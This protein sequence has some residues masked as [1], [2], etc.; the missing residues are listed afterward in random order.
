MLLSGIGMPGVTHH[1][2]DLSLG[3]FPMDS[4]YQ[5]GVAVDVCL[6]GHVVERAV[7]VGAEVDDD[8]VGDGLLLAEVPGL[9]FI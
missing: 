7:I 9:R 1:R 4:L 3:I 5:F 6:S 8:N 2:Y